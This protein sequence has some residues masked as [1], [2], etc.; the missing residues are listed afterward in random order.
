MQEYDADYIT[1]RVKALLDQLPS[2]VGGSLY[3][4]RILWTESYKHTEG[5]P[6]VIRQAKAFAN[7]LNNIPIV[8]YPNELIVG[9]HPKGI[10]S[11]EDNQRLKDAHEYW[12]GK[13]LWDRVGL[14]LTQAEQMAIQSSVYTS[15]S[16]TGHMTPDFDTVLKFGLKEIKEKVSYEIEN[17]DL[18]DPM[19]SK[20]ATFLQASMITLDA[21]CTFAQRYADEALRLAELENNPDRK[22]ELINIY[23]VCS[24]APAKPAQTFYEACQVTWFIHLFV[25]LEEGESHAAFAPGR[26]DQ[27]TYPYY[28]NDIKNG[29]ITK[30]SAGELIDCLWIKFNE[31][32]NEIPQTMTLGGTKK[33]GTPGENDLTI[34]CMDS[35]ERLHV[36]NPSLVLRCHN[37]T[38]DVVMDRAFKLIKTG[39]GFPQLYNDDLMYRAMLYAGVDEE[40]ARDAVPGGC[41]ELSV[42]GKTNPWVGNFFNLPKCL[43]IALNNGI[44]PINDKL[45]GLQTR[46]A[47]NLK[48]FDD[49]MEGYK[50]QVSY[51]MELMAASENTHDIAQAEVTPFPFLSSLVSD[52]LINGI[53]ITEGGARY[54]FTEV[55]GVGIANV[56]DS[57]AVIKKL[58]F[59][60]QRISLVS[61]IDITNKDY[62][63]NENIRQM[64]LNEAP[65]YGNNEPYVDEIAKEVVHSFY[66]EVQKY[67]NPRGGKFLPGLLV[68]TLAEGFGSVTGATP[69]G[70]KS[71]EVFSDSIGSA[72][73][74]D[75]EGPTAL[76]NSVTRIDYT[77]V[78]G[79]L[80]FNMKFTSTVLSAND[81]IYKLQ[82]LIRTYFKLGGMQTQINVVD[83]KTLLE[84]QRFPE[85]YRSLIVRV[86]GWS[87]RFVNL[88]KSLQDDIISRT[89][90]KI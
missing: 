59:E 10:P 61:L 70:R 89:D 82:S 40:D 41:V 71:R 66:E 31:I 17:L 65:K 2:L 77:P 81:S 52:C 90:Q 39:M 80:S 43:L 20:K 38:P 4:R 56:A 9:A 55:Q 1:P 63:D 74:R 6:Q 16:K 37:N 87:S 88:S 7:L 25:C 50:Q 57:L 33:D 69:D 47:G 30:A 13:N 45:I 24:R 75:I 49:V 11:D 72:Q 62:K 68:W 54:N 22:N 46:D 64:L 84:A 79:G 35:T 23:K 26:F 27:Y 21:G 3:S 86:S 78:V 34:L 32:G 53:D 42:H 58:V 60:E 5:Q 85:K 83:R 15:S 8:I 76:I 48:T 51:F 18:A 36:L 19:R 44:D 29:K 28:D 73:G 67:R 12:Q 14:V